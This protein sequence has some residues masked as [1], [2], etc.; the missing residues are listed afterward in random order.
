MSSQP[1]PA[2]L[3]P[4][5]QVSRFGP[6]RLRQENRFENGT[7]DQQGFNIRLPYPLDTSAPIKL[8]LTFL[9]S[10]DTAGDARFVIRWAYTADGDSVYRTTTTAPTT[11]PNEQELIQLLTISAADTQMSQR[12]ELDVSNMVS[13]RISGE[14]DLLWVSIERTGTHGDDTYGGYVVIVNMDAYYT[15]WNNGGHLK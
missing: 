1:K 10:S 15:K 2:P 5:R 14:G 4:P 7:T 8:L 6:P 13:R 3:A 12:I 11:G 9:G